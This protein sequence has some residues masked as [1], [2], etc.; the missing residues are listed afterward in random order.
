[1]RDGS[2]DRRSHLSAPERFG[3]RKYGAGRNPEELV[4]VMPAEIELGK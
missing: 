4:V 3:K 1:M 2:L